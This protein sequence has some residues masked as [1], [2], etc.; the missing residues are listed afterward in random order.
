MVQSL[1]IQN[2]VSKITEIWTTWEKQWD[3]QKVEIWLL[4]S[5]K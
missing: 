5:K 4:G 2:L 1:G 3:N